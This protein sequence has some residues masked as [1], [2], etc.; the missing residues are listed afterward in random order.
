[1]PRPAVTGTGVQIGVGQSTFPRDLEKRF[2]RYAALKDRRVSN[3]IEKV[4][5]ALLKGRVR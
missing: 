4:V 5:H 1:M 3:T 2:R